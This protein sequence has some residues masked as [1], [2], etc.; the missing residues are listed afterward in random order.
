M[1]S[2]YWVAACCAYFCLFCVVVGS[3]AIWIRKKQKVRP[4][5]EF[6]LLRGPGETLRKRMAKYDEDLIFKIAGAALLPPMV[7]LGILIGLLKLHPQTWPQVY[8]S[9]GLATAVFLAALFFSGRWAIRGLFRYGNDRLGYL[10]ER[11]VSE[12]LEPLL[13]R[14]YR[15]FHDMPAEGSEKSF[16]LDHVTA[17]PGGVAVIEVKTRRKGR[18]R[19]GFKEHVV[20]YDGKQLIWPWGEDRHGL[21]QAKAEAAWLHDW[22]KQRTGIDTPVKPI[23]AL[24]GWFVERKAFGDVTVVNSKSVASAVEGKGPAILTPEQI[25]LISRQLDLVCRD[26]V[27]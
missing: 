8:A 22:I 13:V 10:G 25:D 12:H 21:E 14:G 15:V 5:V 23:L 18:A 1:S 26:V 7:A 19:P 16:N 2:P 4:P 27:D 17:G 9:F 20:A 11:E 3:I 6:K 24:P